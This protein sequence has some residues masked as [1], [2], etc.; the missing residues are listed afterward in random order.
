MKFCANLS[1]MFTEKPFTE[2]YSLAKD[3][4]FK[5]VETGFPFGCTIE[6][7]TGAKQQSNIEQILVNLFTGIILY[8]ITFT[9]MHCIQYAYIQYYL[10]ETRVKV[11]L[12]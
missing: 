1:F 6:Q 7:V 12:V 4:G 2:R 11:N 5:T 3:A 10:Q 8:I 9:T